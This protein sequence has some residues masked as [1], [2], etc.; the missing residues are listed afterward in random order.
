MD[1]VE[2][3]RSTLGA[4]TETDVRAMLQA[5]HEEILRLAKELAEATTARAATRC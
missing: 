3:V 2:K 1:V 4:Y 5:D